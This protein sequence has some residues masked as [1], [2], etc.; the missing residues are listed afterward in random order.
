MNGKRYILLCALCSVLCTLSFAQPRLKTPE[1]WIGAHGGVTAS[2]VMFMPAQD[3]MSPITSACVLGGNGGLTFRYAGHKYCAFQMELNYEHR[4]WR[5]GSESGTYT[6]HSLHYIEVPIFMHLN[7]GSD[8]CRWIF[9]LGPQIGYCVADEKHSIDKPFDWGLAAGTG[10]YVRTKHAGVYELEVRFDFSLGG[11]YGTSVT[12]PYSMA[13][14]MDLSLN[15]GWY[16]PIKVDN[17]QL[18]A[19]KARKKAEKARQKAEKERQK[20]REEEEKRQRELE[21]EYQIQ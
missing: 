20:A 11:V 1:Y 2:T 21:Q 5:V 9:N 6:S 8:I 12:D 18:K 3:Y 14:P 4:G 7:F 15:L 19:E 17:A 16:M 13:N 10:F